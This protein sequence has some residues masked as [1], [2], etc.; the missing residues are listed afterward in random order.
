MKKFLSI[1]LLIALLCTVTACARVDNT[2]QPVEN[3]A[4]DIS[5]R[6]M[7]NLEKKLN[8]CN[9]II[10]AKDYLKT[11]VYSKDLVY[12]DYVDE[13]Y[14]DF[15][16]MSLNNETFQAFFTDDGLR[17][18][19]FMK[20]GNAIDAA[21]SRLLNYWFSEE[22]S[23][24]N[25]YNLFYNSTEE[26]LT[27]MSNNEIVK[28]SL[29]NYAGYGTMAFSKMHEVYMVLDAEDPAVVHLQAAF[30]TFD[31]IDITVTFGNAESDARVDAW[32]ENPIYPDARD[33]WNETDL[34]IFNSVFLPGY[35]DDA[36]PFPSFASY[37]LINDGENFVFNDEVTIRDSHATEEDVADY[38]AVLVKEGFA[39]VDETEDDGTVKTYY[40]RMLRED[41]NCYTSV[42][43]EYDDGANIIARKYYETDKYDKLDDVNNIIEARG[44]VA[45][46]ESS[47]CVSLSAFNSPDEL[48]ESWL[49]FFNYELN[50]LTELKFSSNEKLLDYISEYEK[51]IA[52]S[53]FY[54]VYT[55]DSEEEIDHYKSENETSTFRYHL[56]DDETVTFLYRTE[57]LISA[58]EAADKLSK[59]GFPAVKFNEDLVCR[60][61]TRFE[62]FQY[63]KD[64]DMYL[65]VSLTFNSTQNADAFLDPYV[66]ALED[67]GFL[68]VNPENIGSGKAFAYYNEDINK[69]VAFSYYDSESK[70]DILFD[71]VAE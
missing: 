67:A 40:R 31:D 52:D 32:L 39:P 1:L 21:I 9:Y 23:E 17:D 55:D 20:D 10:D 60:D 54:P 71:F 29:L 7:E 47:D 26:P 25:I 8:E 43:V 15:A 69:Y 6:A 44:F 3:D 58:E 18:V 12:F 57:K 22:I 46:P 61:L 66:A 19:T 5:E 45:L 28:N 59:S 4:A 64:Y 11:V 42:Y 50:L 27:F 36:I 53:G 37:A 68:R 2:P 48:T 70:V 35:G 30:D 34:F 33:G 16:V 62:K 38:T 13:I 63:G 65:T 49:Y 24:G 56:E 41:Y 14:N 51:A